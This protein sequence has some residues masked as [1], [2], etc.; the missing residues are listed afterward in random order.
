MATHKGELLYLNLGMGTHKDEL[1]SLNLGIATHM[2]ELASLK[3][4]M[5]THKGE[6]LSLKL[7]NPYL[8]IFIYCVIASTTIQHCMRRTSHL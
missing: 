5:G 7:E 3:L 6:L 8:Y 1:V 4:G 2:C